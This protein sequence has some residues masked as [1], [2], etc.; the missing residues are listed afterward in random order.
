LTITQQH[1]QEQSGSNKRASTSS[2]SSSSNGNGGNESAPA[3]AP[4][5]GNFAFGGAPA[6]ATDATAPA[7]TTPAPGG[8]GDAGHGTPAPGAFT[9]ATPATPAPVDTPAPTTP[10]TSN[11]ASTTPTTTSVPPKQP[12]VLDYQTLTVEQIINK[13][14][15][16]LEKDAIVYLDQAKRV[17]EYDA[18]LRDSQRNLS[19]LT[20]HAQRMILQ[21]GEVERSLSTIAAVQHELQSDLDEL[22]TNVHRL[23]A[24]QAHMTP[25][26]ADTA[27]ERSYATALQLEQ[28]LQAMARSFQSTIRRL[29]QATHTATTTTAATATA[30]SS[31]NSS[32]SSSDLKNI[33]TILNQHQDSLDHLDRVSKRMETDMAMI[34]KALAR[35]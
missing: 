33:L 23:F 9:P 29:D 25:V 28:D 11:T 19:R 24:S 22:D 1:D 8:G 4:T 12:P 2:L 21:Q 18:V 14:Q 6:A 32:D 30:S 35:S 20:E 31:T 7:P 13:F 17:A 10:A 16:E 34:E 5:F 3:P 15:S 26:D 27:R